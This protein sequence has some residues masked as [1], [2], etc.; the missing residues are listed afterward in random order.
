VWGGG[1]RK[2]GFVKHRE[3]TAQRGGR[4]RG[5]GM[6]RPFKAEE[7]F[8]SGGRGPLHWGKTPEKGKRAS[9]KKTGSINERGGPHWKKA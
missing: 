7:K 3:R 6:N 8:P 5:G 1:V 9:T 4:K 2:K